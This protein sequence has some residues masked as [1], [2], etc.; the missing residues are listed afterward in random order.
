MNAW[1]PPW[2]PQPP[3]PK[4]KWECWVF[5][6]PNMLV[7]KLAYDVSWWTRFRTRIFLGSKWKKLS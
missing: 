2:A 6:D 1:D 3:P 7:I 4:L 5:G